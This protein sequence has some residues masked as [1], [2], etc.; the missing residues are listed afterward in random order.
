MNK[1][2]KGIK[3]QI[4][5]GIRHHKSFKSG[6]RTGPRK[7]LPENTGIA[8]DVIHRHKSVE[9]VSTTTSTFQLPQNFS[10]FLAYDKLQIKQYCL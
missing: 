10:T 4:G 6:W 9:Y 5:S 8:G 7:T 2:G 3:I 1:G